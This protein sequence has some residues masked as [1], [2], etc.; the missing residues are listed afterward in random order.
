MGKKVDRVTTSFEDRYQTLV[1][2]CSPRCL[3]QR[4]GGPI[5]L[6]TGRPNR[7][8]LSIISSADLVIEAIRRSDLSI[9]PKAGSAF[10]FRSRGR[11]LNTYGAP[12]AFSPPA[13]CCKD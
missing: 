4:A 12:R 13:T 5:T 10:A 11:L 6:H 3:L 8:D 2:E 1:H 9:G 7:L